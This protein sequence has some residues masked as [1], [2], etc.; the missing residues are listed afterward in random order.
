MI[1]RL[2]AAILLSALTITLPSDFVFGAQIVRRPPIVAGGKL[3]PLTAGE[4]NALGCEVIRDPNCPRVGGKTSRCSC[5][6]GT[7]CIDEK[8]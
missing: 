7:M 4:C 1:S 3:A 8:K 2:V 5:S 6:T